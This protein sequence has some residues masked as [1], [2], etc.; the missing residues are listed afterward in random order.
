MNSPDNRPSGGVSCLAVVGIL[1]VMMVIAL[2]I[3]G[4][5]NSLKGLPSGIAFI[6][7][8]GVCAV[9]VYLV[10]KSNN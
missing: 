5:S 2:I 6:I 7:G 1:A 3:N 8:I 10:M 4:S 9:V